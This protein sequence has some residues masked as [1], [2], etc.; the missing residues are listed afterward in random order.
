LSSSLRHSEWFSFVKTL[1]VTY[2][3]RIF[4]YAVHN[5]KSQ[6][7][8]PSQRIQS[9]TRTYKSLLRKYICV[10]GNQEIADFSYAF[11]SVYN[12]CAPA[13]FS[14]IKTSKPFRC[15]FQHHKTYTSG[16]YW[17]W[18]TNKNWISPSSG[19]AI[20]LNFVDVPKYNRLQDWSIKLW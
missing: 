6:V 3:T 15:S 17:V 13:E 10:D 4:Q 16:K 20:E 11:R 7:A 19:K 14:I 5:S 12:S 8:M 9:T 2:D 18:K 1:F